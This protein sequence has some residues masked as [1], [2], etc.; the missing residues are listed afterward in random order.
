MYR[1]GCLECG[2]TCKGGCLECG[3]TC[4]GGS[5]NNPIYARMLQLQHE[6]EKNKV[7]FYGLGT[8]DNPVFRRRLELLQRQKIARAN[9]K[10]I[11]MTMRPRSM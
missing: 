4:G 6:R 7:P 1:A 10:N 3:G 2:G 8:M 5:F 11:N 9:N